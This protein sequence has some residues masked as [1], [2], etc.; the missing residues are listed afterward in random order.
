MPLWKPTDISAVKYSTAAGVP[1]NTPETNLWLKT[2]DVVGA[3]WKDSSFKEYTASHASAEPSKSTT[4]KNGKTGLNFNGDKALTVGPSNASTGPMDVGTD[5]YY[6]GAFVKHI[7]H[8][9]TQV[10]C[11]N[12]SSGAKFE[13]RFSAGEKIVAALFQ[14]DTAT[15]TTT[16]ANNTYYWAHSYR[17]GANAYAGFDDTRQDGSDTDSTDSISKDA[18]FHI[19]ARSGSSLNFQSDIFE[20]LV[21]HQTPNLDDIKRIEGY[22]S[23]KFDN[24]GNL[25]ASHE[26]KYGPPTCCHCVSEQ[27]LS[28]SV[29][30]SNPRNPAE[31][32]ENL[33]T[34][35][36]RR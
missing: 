10:I 33:N 13:L 19:G 27:T 14:S 1:E 18:A 34:Y 7:D 15:G 8:D 5:G 36:E 17:D 35:D 30:S 29:L 24:E 22:V 26:Y 25:G 11:C 16:L 21:I 2:E 32:S 6:V 9:A 4:L 20:V 23:H 31:L 3:D 28:T 12:D